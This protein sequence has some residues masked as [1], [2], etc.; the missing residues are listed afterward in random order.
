MNI[1]KLNPADPSTFGSVELTS[2]TSFSVENTGDE[3]ATGGDGGAY[4]SSVHMSN[5]AFSVSVNGSD[6]GYTIE[7][8]DCDDLV[9]NSISKTN[10]CGDAAVAKTFTFAQAVVTAVNRTVNHAGNSEYSITFKPYSTDG[11]ASP[12]VLS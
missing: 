2:L 10:D 11:I 1:F 6:I 4:I 7:V 9:L 12:L 8:G 3:E 5:I